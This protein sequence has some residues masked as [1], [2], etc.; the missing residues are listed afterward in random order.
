[1]TQYSDEQLSKILDRAKWGSLPPETI[2]QIARVL[3]SS[4]APTDQEYTLL[5]ILGRAGGREYEELIA[6]FLNSPQ[7]PML[8]RLA[9]QAL[10]GWL[11][12]AAKYRNA[13]LEFISWVPWDV[14]DDVRLMAISQSGEYLR[15]ATDR[16]LLNAL[17]SV[18]RDDA[19]LPLIR[20]QAVRAL[21]RALGHDRDSLPLAT[22][23]VGPESEWAL[24]VLG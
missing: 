8:A 9:L 3:L 6:S 18:A 4:S 24:D 12:L 11:G 5:H 15:D 1:M 22:T 16:E 17:Y 19:E 7:N 13:L 14:S 21:A 10:C 23:L 20:E 2:K